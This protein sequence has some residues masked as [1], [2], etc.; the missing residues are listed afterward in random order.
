[1]AL[2]CKGIRNIPWFIY[3]M[4]RNYGEICLVFET[5]R[6]VAWDALVIQTTET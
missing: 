2:A 6:T 4:K 1:M 3:N 5:Y